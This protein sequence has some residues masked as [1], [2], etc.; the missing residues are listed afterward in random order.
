MSSLYADAQR[1]GVVATTPLRPNLH[2][3]AAS[4]ATLHHLADPAQ[5]NG[6]TGA[7]HT[8]LGRGLRARVDRPLRLGGFFVQ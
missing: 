5:Q 6:Q 1:I 2:P 4:A 3:L 7:E 8:G